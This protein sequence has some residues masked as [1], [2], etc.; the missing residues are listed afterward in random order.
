MAPRPLTSALSVASL[1]VAACGGLATSDPRTDTAT[2][3]GTTTG[4]TTT[5][6]TT[7]GGT[8][9]GG[10]TTGGTT[11]GGT[12]AGGSGASSAGTAG[13]NG[14]SYA[15]GGG[16]VAGAGGAGDGCGEDLLWY[17]VA[18]WDVGGLGECSPRHCVGLREP[19]GAVVLDGEGR[20]SDITGI[21]PAYEAAFMEEVASEVWVCLA[22]Q[23][24][25]Y[26]CSLGH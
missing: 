8:T 18:E 3:G 13:E 19:W 24:L 12:S 4:G 7:T 23:R 1:L 10:T 16:S 25:E 11:T 20:V 17:L 2:T 9:T 15:G 6:G 14:G 26:C 5:G 21:D 22:D